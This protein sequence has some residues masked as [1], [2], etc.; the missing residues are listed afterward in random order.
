MSLD[1][2]A[3]GGSIV[4]DLLGDLYTIPIIGG[5][6]Q[7]ITSGPAFDRQPRFSPDGRQLAFVSDRG[8]S[9]NLWIADHDGR[10]ARQ[11]SHLEGYP[12]GAVTSPAWSPDGRTI[13]VSQMLGA[14]R[15]GPV[16]WRESMRW[17]LA[18]YDLATG[19]MGWIGDTAAGMTRAMLGPAFGPRGDAVYAS[20]DAPNTDPYNEMA[21]PRVVRVELGSGRILPEMSVQAGR[22]GMRPAVSRD[23]RYLVYAS[24]SGSHLGLRLRDLRTDRERWLVREV[25]D[26]QPFLPALDS[27]DLVPGFAITPD[28]ETVIAAYGGKIHRITI[29]TGTSSVIPFD[30]DLEQSL[31]PLALR[32]FTIRDTAVRTHAVMH[33]ALS[34]DGQRVA[35]SAL[36]RIWVLELP[37]SGQAVGSPSRLTADSVGEFFPSWSPDGQWIA[38]STWVDGEGGG[39]RR[40]RA[41][42]GP[43]PA[44][45]ERLTDDTAVYFNT[46][47][48]PN[49]KR[50]VAV[51]AGLPPDRAL[52]WGPAADPRLVWVPS[53]GGDPQAIAPLRKEQHERHPYPVDQLYFTADPH[54]IYLGLTSWNWDGTDRRTTSTL[55]TTGPGVGDDETDGVLSPDRCRALVVRKSGLFEVSLDVPPNA[56]SDSGN[57]TA[58]RRGRMLR[59]LGMAPAPWIS[60]SRD[61][62]RVLFTQGGT[63]FVAQQSLGRWTPFKQLDV[64]LAVSMDQPRGTLVLQGARLITMRGQQVIARGDVVIRDN[65]ILAVGASGTLRIP[66]GA[67]VVDLT[68]ATI[69][70]GYVDVHDHMLLPKGVHPGQCWQCLVRL[71]YGVTTTRDPQPSLAHD[72]FTYR[73][74]ERAG[75]LLSPRLFSSGMAYAGS[76]P[77]IRTLDDALAAVRPYADYLGAE[78]FKIHYDPAGS[79]RRRQLLLIAAARVGLNVTV[80]G[81]GSELGLATVI[82]GFAGLEHLLPVRIY[83]DVA[84]LIAR[85][86]TIHTQTFGGV[87]PGASN[88][89]FRRY[90]DLWGNARMRRLTPPSGRPLVCSWCMDETFNGPPE[91][92]NLLPLLSSAA[93]IARKGGRIAIGSHGNIP[94]IGFHY[95]MWLHA[96]GGMPAHD[97]LRSATLVGATAIGHVRDLGSLEAGKLADLQILSKNPLDD[98]RNTTSIRY[99]MKNGRLHEAD[100]LTQIW[101]RFERLPATYLW[102]RRAQP[103]HGAALN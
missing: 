37:Y 97:I 8:G 5:R 45:S 99:V 57:L 59:S 88:Y 92:D 33:A 100:S 94:G 79:R 95:E 82:D 103:S 61:G 49:G 47:V 26:D 63:L 39:L 38:Y 19:R 66:L 76:E 35:F 56:A 9:A 62:R 29:A 65:R 71:A 22:T 48:E 46:A 58:V 54:R 93:R 17:L 3:D 52:L 20:A 10:H 16:A 53:S 67:R 70:P 11:L 75:S 2:A 23:G 4:F 13:I 21:S 73:E 101:P 87:I 14:T 30:A 60:W 102:P 41:A 81:Q 98:I 32:Q 90:G 64:P 74:R 6:A 1:V 25:I 7:R 85:A 77:P 18:G 34:P 91:L 12:Y 78:T 15:P 43:A 84:M 27:R 96:L 44:P 69:L 55:T 72:V 42:H 40:T 89:L 28:G 24:S 51:R 68:G 80:H 86:G 36:D 31:G 83:D 50:V